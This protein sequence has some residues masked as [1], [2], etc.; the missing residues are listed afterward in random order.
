MEKDF[1]TPEQQRVL[2]ENS[3]LISQ[4]GLAHEWAEF[5]MGSIMST[6]EFERE[7]ASNPE[8]FKPVL[9]LGKVALNA[10]EA[11]FIVLGKKVEAAHSSALDLNIGKVN[12]QNGEMLA[13]SEGPILDCGIIGKHERWQSSKFNELTDNELA[14][15]VKQA[16]ERFV[17]PGYFDPILEI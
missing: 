16:L 9:D 15:V 8:E 2:V 10:L 14:Q 12:P 13:M 1:F 3:M 7:R 5:S 6:V 4:S 11:P 17:V